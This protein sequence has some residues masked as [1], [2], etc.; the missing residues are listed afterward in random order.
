MSPLFKEE[1][2]ITITS[3]QIYLYP[4]LFFFLKT[5]LFF[6]SI[7]IYRYNRYKKS[8]IFR[9]I[10]VTTSSCCCHCSKKYSS[11]ITNYE[12]RNLRAWRLFQ[13]LSQL[14]QQR[15]LVPSKAY[16][17]SASFW[18]YVSNDALRLMIK[19]KSIMELNVKQI[20]HIIKKRILYTLG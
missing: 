6:S 8:T 7:K 18:T 14:F 2:S 17:L 13:Q 9:I 1:T 4:N 12:W 20:K 16:N 11:R 15:P 3:E 19:Y 10:R 5:G